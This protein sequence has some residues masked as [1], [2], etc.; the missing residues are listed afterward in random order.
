MP[1]FREEICGPLEVPPYK[2]IDST[3]QELPA[4]H[5]TSD[6]YKQLKKT[7]RYYHSANQ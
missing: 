3:P 7:I 5:M 2:Q 4:S 6:I 1:D